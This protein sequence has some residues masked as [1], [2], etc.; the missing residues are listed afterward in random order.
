M[1]TLTQAMTR[2]VEAHTNLNTYQAVIAI[3]EGGT[4]YDGRTHAP[5]NKI[6]KIAKAE[7]QKE[8]VIF[9]D[10]QRLIEGGL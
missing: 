8:L 5:A 4:L 3:L 6:I 10:M 2:M 7:Q 9:E 1:T